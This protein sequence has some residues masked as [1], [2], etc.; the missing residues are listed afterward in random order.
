MIDSLLSTYRG[1]VRCA[2]ASGTAS[3]RRLGFVVLASLL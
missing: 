2:S 1:M 3:L